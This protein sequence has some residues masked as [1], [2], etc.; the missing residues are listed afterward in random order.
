[1]IDK[2]MTRTTGHISQQDISIEAVILV[3]LQVVG[4]CC[5]MRRC[6]N[7]DA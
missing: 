3:D 5:A 1:M 6:R 7:D 2:T 4:I